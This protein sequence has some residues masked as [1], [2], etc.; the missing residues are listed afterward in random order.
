MHF[1]LDE[2]IPLQLGNILKTYNHSVS[3]VFSEKISG[4]KDK[5]LLDICNKNN[6]VLITLDK[7][8][9]S[10]QAYPFQCHKGIVILRLKSQGAI[11]VI[12]AFENFIKTISLERTKNSFIIVEEK[13]IRIR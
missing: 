7:D 9:T 4:V 1:K 13:N 6:F 2:N 5:E 10:V 3:S 11:S 12:S 8:F